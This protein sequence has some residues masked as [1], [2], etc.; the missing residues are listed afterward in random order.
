MT[1]D[2][3][4]TAPKTPGPLDRFWVFCMTQLGRL[5]M[6]VVEGLTVVGVFLVAVYVGWFLVT[7]EINDPTRLRMVNLIETVNNNWKA[8]LLLL[9]LLFYRTIRAFLEEV[10]EAFGIKRR[11]LPPP[12]ASPQTNPPQ[13]NVSP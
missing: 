5:V 3:Q 2:T 13:T 4:P 6:K 7:K 9:I 8:F 10:Q 1:A 12:P 11:P